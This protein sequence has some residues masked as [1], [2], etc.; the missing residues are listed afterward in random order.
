MTTDFRTLYSSLRTEQ[1]ELNQ[2]M[3][4]ARADAI[5][6]AQELV[7]VFGIRASD[8]H[9]PNRSEQAAAAA[10]ARRPR[11]PAPIKYRTPTGVV[12]SGKGNMKKAFREYLHSQGLT[13]ADKDLFLTE[14][15]KK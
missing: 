15:F 5:V 4:S 14:A 10:G 2:K 11:G 1:D 6:Y 7:D 13:E 12:W 9:F 3:K 8:L